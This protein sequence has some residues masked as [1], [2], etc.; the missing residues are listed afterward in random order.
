M[1]LFGLIW[2]SL[3]QHRIRTTL[4]LLSVLVAFLLFGLLQSVIT[5]FGAGVEVVGADRL[6]VSP[7]FSIIDPLPL[8]HQSV[9]ASVEGVDQITHASWFGGEYQDPRNFFPK[10]PVEPD[11]YFELYPEFLLSDVEKSAFRSIQ[12]GAVV[13]RGLADR[14]NWSLGD[15]I[16]IKPSIYPK[17]DGSDTW[18]F[19]LVGIFDV[20]EGE[21]DPELFLFNYKYFEEAAQFGSGTVSWYVVRIDDPEAAPTI[22][23]RIDKLFENSVNPTKTATEAEMQR[24]FMSQMGDI[25]FMM[26]GILGAVFFTIILL[27]ANT[28][29]QSFRERTAQYAVLKTLGFT[30]QKV[31]FI[32]ISESILLIVAGA[33]LGLALAA[34]VAQGLAETL[35]RML[36]GFTVELSTIVLGLGIALLLG[37]VVGAVP[38]Y[39]ANRLNIVEALRK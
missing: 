31:T 9:I 37:L 4:T 19:D 8:A 27:T 26:T 35:A 34:L 20:A 29:V 5:V 15:R 39:S 17:K 22:S 14:F 7:K 33:V 1:S 13:S 28:M 2:M 24:Q 12:T 6:M 25:G 10:F 21:L 16:P 18:E 23:Q 11:A 36:P 32:V 3:F 38:A 30:D